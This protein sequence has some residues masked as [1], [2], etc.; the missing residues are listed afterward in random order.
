VA[1]ILYL[2]DETWQ[3]QSTVITFLERELG[4]TVTLVGSTDDA[5]KELSATPYDAVFLDIMLDLNQGT[6][7]FEKSGLMIAQLVLNGEF[8]EAGN[9]P[10]L[11][12]IIASGVWDAT[13]KN[14]MG[15]GWTVE[16]RARSLGI[17]HRYFLHKPFLIDEV[18]QVLEQALQ[19]NAED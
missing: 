9:P 6:I 1:N 13:V 2:E 14:S 5:R 18:R 3:V 7:D 4:H 16:D 8:E 19:G 17:S 11:P 10:T 12:T 15:R